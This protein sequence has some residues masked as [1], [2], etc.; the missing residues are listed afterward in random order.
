MNF[1]PNK[2]LN[3]FTADKAEE[4]IKA[5]MHNNLLELKSCVEEEK[6]GH[7][8]KLDGVGYKKRKYDSDEDKNLGDAVFRV[9][10]DYS[11]YYYKFIYPVDEKD[12]LPVNFKKFEKAYEK[13]PESSKLHFENMQEYRK[14]FYPK[15]E[16]EKTVY[17]FATLCEKEIE[18]FLITA[19][20]VSLARKV[21]S[22]IPKE[23]SNNNNTRRAFLGKAPL[24]KSKEKILEHF[25]KEVVEAYKLQEA[26]EYSL[27]QCI[28]GDGYIEF[29]EYYDLPKPENISEKV[30][31]K[32]LAWGNGGFYEKTVSSVPHDYSLRI[33]WEKFLEEN[34]LTPDCKLY[35]GEI[36]YLL[37][38]P[39]YENEVFQTVIYRY[40]I[41]EKYKKKWVPKILKNYLNKEGKPDHGRIPNVY[42]AEVDYK[43]AKHKMEWQ[44]TYYRHEGWIDLEKPLM[45]KNLIAYVLNGE[46][47]EGEEV[48][49]S[50]YEGSCKGFVYETPIPLEDA[51]NLHVAHANMWECT[52]ADLDK[53]FVYAVNRSEEHA[54]MAP[55]YQGLKLFHFVE[56]L[57]EKDKDFPFLT[58]LQARG[59]IQFNNDQET[60]DN[61]KVYSD[62]NIT[63]NKL[64]KLTKVPNTLKLK[65]WLDDILYD[66]KYSSSGD[67]TNVGRYVCRFLKAL[68]LHPIA[69]TY[70]DYKEHKEYN[71][72]NTELIVGLNEEG[73]DYSYNYSK[74][75]WDCV[76]FNDNEV[77]VIKS[78]KMNEY[79]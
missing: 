10:D 40:K 51:L 6:L 13:I 5:F 50:I 20:D 70:D 63:V 28:A 19:T 49:S 2:I 52:C 62:N 61:W 3:V 29:Y 77:V 35:D 31:A 37:K 66:T 78:N 76:C 64:E 15:K 7:L 16:D 73:K 79:V 72:S 55:E 33:K 42:R 53:R 36:K 45:V 14:T 57:E 71:T 67:A 4:G 44:G 54:V 21:F 65:M 24:E 69:G 8:F 56:G 26:K 38:Y 12:L 60:Y 11:N 32:E 75:F 25:E 41:V 34:N 47:R 22:N 18:S 17:V 30:F 59:L 68:N 9:K 1:D 46:F 23:K 39:E 43:N 58:L 27:S 48:Y 74:E